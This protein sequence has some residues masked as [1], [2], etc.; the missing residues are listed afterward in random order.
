MLSAI[1]AAK[2][3]MVDSV[4]YESEAKDFQTARIARCYRA[5]QD[6]LR[7]NNALDFDDLLFKTVPALRGGR[8]CARLLSGA[9]SLYHGG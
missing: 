8:R 5:Y 2:N 1:S 4:R 6:L 9:L 3:E 7:K